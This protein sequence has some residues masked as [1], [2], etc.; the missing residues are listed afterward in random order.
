ME[1]LQ[2]FDEKDTRQK[3]IMPKIN[4]REVAY[5]GHTVRRENMHRQ[6]LARKSM[7]TEAGEDLELN[8]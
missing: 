8:G 2:A 7:E 6:L 5:Y 4:E 1:R 3:Y